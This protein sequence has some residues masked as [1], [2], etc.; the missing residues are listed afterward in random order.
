MESTAAASALQLPAPVGVF[1]Y[2]RPRHARRTLEALRNN[3]GANR[4]PLYIF[5]DGP[6]PGAPQ[7]VLHQVAAV[8]KL[9]EDFRWPGPKKEIYAAATNKG[10]ARSIID[11]TT[12][13]CKAYG[14]AIL[15]EDDIVTS[16]GFLEYM[17]RALALYADTPE[18]MHVSGFFY[19]IKTDD[20]PE[21]F[22][23]NITTCWGWATWQRA[24]QHMNEDREALYR[25]VEVLPDRSAYDLNGAADFFRQLEHNFTGKRITWAVLWYTVL[26]F[27]GGLC[28]HPRHSL[29]NNIGNDGSGE[30]SRTS[31]FFWHKQLADSV[32]V[33][34]IPLEEY[35][36]A[37]QRMEA[38]YRK[39]ARKARPTFGKRL[40]AKLRLTYQQLRGKA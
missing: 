25:Q 27:K 12:K 16:P 13:L 35:L 6:K 19:P 15:V 22:F 32:E 21:T 4:T 34:P 31:K 14:A 29:T 1:L 24:W 37:R 10:L 26:F 5:C 3:R 40:R 30:N 39:L 28:L 8:R 7:E 20:F 9:A 23:Y 2:N 18:V 11:G 36:P 38:F 33:A 17:N